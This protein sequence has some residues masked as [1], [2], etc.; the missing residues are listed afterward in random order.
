MTNDLYAVVGNPISHSKSPRIHSL[1]AQ[2]TGEAVEYTAIQAPLEDFAGTVHHF[3][4]HG[5]KGLN[6]TV[7]FK[8]QAW[9]LAEHRTHQA[10]LAGAAN[11]LYLDQEDQ[12]VADNT[13]GVGIVRDLRDNHGVPLKGARVLVLGA[14]G[15]VRGVLG[16]LLDE[17]PAS[18]VVANRTVARAEALAR[19][20]G[21]EHSGIELSACGFEQVEGPFDLVING[22]S[23]SL[24]GDLPP[25]PDALFADGGL[26]YDMMYGAAPTVFLRWAAERGARTV[27]GLGMLI[28]QAAESFYL[29]RG[30]RPDTAAVRERLRRSL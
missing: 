26:A 20:F 30:V 1:F 8:E 17:Q 29:W 22:T 21:R 16:P 2:Q 27:D 14:G 12:L 25:L 28:E 18:V 4:D 11:T 5:G 9:T 10:E 24:A 13:D 23:A 6:I 19:L 3:F 7:P 15:A